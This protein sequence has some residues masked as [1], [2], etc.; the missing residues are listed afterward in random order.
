MGIAGRPRDRLLVRTEPLREGG[1]E[2]LHGGNVEAVESED[3]RVRRIAVI[4]PGP[5]FPAPVLGSLAKHSR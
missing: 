5:N 3:W 1:V 4:V 2:R